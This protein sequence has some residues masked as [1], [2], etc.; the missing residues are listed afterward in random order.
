MD[1]G[2]ISDPHVETLVRFSNEI[3]DVYRKKEAIWKHSPFRWIVT[4][5]SATK[6][7]IAE[8]L[9]SKFFAENGY[10]VEKSGDRQADRVIAGARVEIK[11][12]SLWESRIYKFQQIRDQ[13]YAL[14]VCLGISPLEAHCW[15]IP[16]KVLMDGRNKLEGLGGQHGGKSGND[17]AWLEVNPQAPQAWLKEYGGSLAEAL[18]TFERLG[19][20]NDLSR[21]SRLLW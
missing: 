14:L 2:Q 8:M 3:R 18:L 1:F 16:K 11:M 13:N 15:V 7:K 5:P 17:T 9:V 20:Q 6:G 4:R 19:G 21:R 10:V 12:S